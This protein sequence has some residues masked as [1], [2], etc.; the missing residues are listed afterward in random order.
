MRQ[1]QVLLA[2]MQ[3]HNEVH[4]SVELRI[5]PLYTE[6]YSQWLLAIL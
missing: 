6:M 2:A 3:Q 4:N 1:M 5:A